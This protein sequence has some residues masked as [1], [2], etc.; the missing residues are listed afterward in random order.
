[1][2]VPL[3]DQIACVK[4]ELAL[5]RSAYPR[6]V[7]GHKL[8]QEKADHELAAMAAVL[9]TLEAGDQSGAPE[10]E[11]E[12]LAPLT[13]R[14]AF[15]RYWITDETG[16]SVG[17]E[18]GYA[19]VE[20]ARGAADGRIAAPAIYDTADEPGNV[21]PAPN[22]SADR[23]AVER[24]ARLALN[25]GE[26]RD[27]R[28]KFIIRDPRNAQRLSDALRSVLAQLADAKAKYER[29]HHVA[30][31]AGVVVCNDGSLVYSQAERLTAAESTNA[32]LRARV[33]EL[34]AALKPF[35]AMAGQPILIKALGSARISVDVDHFNRARALLQPKPE[36]RG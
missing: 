14:H 9:A 21:G 4:R 7:A 6:W 32:T 10:Q 27:D 33:A 34:E 8:T 18:D 12:Q 24:V 16:K 35:A 28:F 31:A 20:A 22:P 23:E 19:T 2:T 1:M 29:W 26:A 3:A 5:R 11:R 17:S 36:G 15:G 13:I 30:M 25:L